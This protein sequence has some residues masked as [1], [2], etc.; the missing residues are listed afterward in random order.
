MTVCT[1]ANSKSPW[2][3]HC[4]SQ[5]GLSADESFAQ[6]WTEIYQL[7]VSGW[8][9][10]KYRGFDSIGV[11]RDAVGAGAPPR[12]RKNWGGGLNLWG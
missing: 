2:T 9:R 5:P 4:R 11:A 6:L 1:G 3:H 8:H 12:A 7:V 10:A